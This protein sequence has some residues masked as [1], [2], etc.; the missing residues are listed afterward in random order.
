VLPPPENKK[1]NDGERKNGR[2]GEQSVIGGEENGQEAR[3][4]P[5]PVAE[6][7]VARFEGAAVDKVVG[8]EGGKKANQDDHGEDRVAKEKLGNMRNGFGR[9]GSISAQHK[10]ILAEGFDREDDENHSI[11]VINVEHE[12]RD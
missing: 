3:R 4:K 5:V 9:R 12:T 10:V 6:R 11:G 2:P 1:T 7:N 8:D